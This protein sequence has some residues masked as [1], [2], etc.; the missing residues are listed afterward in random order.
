MQLT[1][2][3]TS[4]FIVPTLQVP[5]DALKNNGFINGYIID[6][7]KDVQYENAVYLL[8]KP[9]CLDKFREF[10]ENE[11]ERTKQIIEDYDYDKGYVVVV[12]KLNENLK[13]DFDLIKQGKYSKTSDNFKKLFPKE[14]QIKDNKG[15]LKNELSLQ[16]RIFNKTED[17]VDFWEK[18]LGVDLQSI[19]GENF[20]VWE[21]FDMKR[22][23]L[24]IKNFK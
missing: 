21:G 1:K 2:T 16:Y 13:E 24:N 7:T 18:K 6:K 11:Y 8:F 12:Y 14:I 10:L 19:S 4:I 20:E 15:F 3:I 5:K 9:N 22:E 17:L 23:T